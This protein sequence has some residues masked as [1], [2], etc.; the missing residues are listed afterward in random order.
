MSDQCT[1]C[2]KRGDLAGCQTTDCN[3]HESWYAKRLRAVNAEL[4]EAGTLAFNLL[5]NLLGIDEVG[6]SEICE[7]LDAALSHAEGR[8]SL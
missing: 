8:K 1:H 4:V 3:Q 7:K 2:I 5:N 6:N